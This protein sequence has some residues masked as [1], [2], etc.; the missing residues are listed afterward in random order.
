MARP[1]LCPVVV[2]RLCGAICL[3]RTR[4]LR[5]AFVRAS[6]RFRVC[7]AGDVRC[8]A[9]VNWRVSV[10]VLEASQGIQLL[11]S[12]VEAIES[13]KWRGRLAVRVS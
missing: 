1:V 12:E 13:W 10:E 11:P 5:V 2:R 7:S 4:A 9:A 6:L 3:A 8:I